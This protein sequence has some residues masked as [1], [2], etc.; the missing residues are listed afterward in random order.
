MSQDNLIKLVSQGDEKGVGKGHVIWSK[1][2]VKKLR[3]I[4]LE[5]S[6]FNPFAKKHTI[7]KEKK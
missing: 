2:N 4:K 5:L 1:K 6:K 3:G 7:Y